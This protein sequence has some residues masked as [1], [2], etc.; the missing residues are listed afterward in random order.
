MGLADA[1]PL[2]D[3]CLSRVAVGG[4]WDSFGISDAPGGQPHCI[5][6]A[7]CGV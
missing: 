2:G 6:N 3:W 1:I 4:R 5:V 7:A